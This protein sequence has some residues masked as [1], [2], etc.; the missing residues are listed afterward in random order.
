MLLVGAPALVLTADGGPLGGAS[1]AARTGVLVLVTLAAAAGAI[2]HRP[3]LP[4]VGWLIVGTV[5]LNTVNAAL[6]EQSLAMVLLGFACGLGAIG[7][8][9]YS[10]RANVSVGPAVDAL[11]A[12]M[13][14]FVV[15][16]VAGGQQ[17]WPGDAPAILGANFVVLLLV[18]F[19]VSLPYWVPAALVF[20]LAAIAMSTVTDVAAL[21]HSSFGTTT[22]AV[23]AGWSLLLLAV[24]TL[25]PTFASVT[26]PVPLAD[27]RHRATRVLLLSSSLALTVALTFADARFLQSRGPLLTAATL[28]LVGLIA[29]RVV[30]WIRHLD[31]IARVT[32]KRAETDDLTGLR[33]PQGLRAFAETGGADGRRIDAWSVIAF[34]LDG[35]RRIND[36]FGTAAGDAALRA[37]GSTLKALT[38]PDGVTGRLGADEF[39]ML[40]PGADRVRARRL[41]M[42]GVAAIRDLVDG[43]DALGRL[44]LPASAGIAMA[45]EGPTAIDRLIGQA[46]TA[47]GDVQRHGGHTVGEFAPTM[48]AAASEDLE[49]LRDLQR[50]L[51]RGVD[52]IEPAFQPIVDLRTGRIVAV[53]ALA[54]WTTP[55]GRKVAPDRYLALAEASGWI[56]Q[57][58][59][60]MLRRSCEDLVR[61]RE[62]HP[63]LKVHVN[64]SPV[65]A[66]QSSFIA[67]ALETVSRA[68]L[69][70]D[71]VV[72]EVTEQVLLPEAG[73]ELEAFLQLSEA[74]LGLA[75]D[76]FGSGYASVGYLARLRLNYIKIDRAFTA[77][78]GT[79]NALLDDLLPFL[80]ARGATVIVEG[81]ETKDQYHRLQELDCA[82][83]QGYL[84]G[85]PVSATEICQRL[86][87]GVDVD[88]PRR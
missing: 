15:V 34:D 70:R 3:S 52:E 51:G 86:A 13:G 20:G 67:F 36:A 63:D 39:A 53:E 56:G 77:E 62:F 32:R 16:V 47:V 8:I 22:T 1:G 79:D 14:P 64:V 82:L 5:A 75:L 55:D 66:G 71:A 11:A 73:A 33:S 37:V 81:V 40:V 4:V 25:H 50:A 57:L 59:Q 21:M 29:F 19:T 17:P 78:L 45:E 76:D 60:R 38:P 44:S 49:M 35:F 43:G 88:T 72:L 61:M 83:G 7:G 68:G 27:Q 41:A 48:V 24:A 10:L 28:A 74:G 69:P 18:A 58:G 2:R 6:P 30:E 26:T 31:D 87:N 80:A 9:L 23:L 54:R 85:R 65:E 84:L 42:T 12:T 46:L